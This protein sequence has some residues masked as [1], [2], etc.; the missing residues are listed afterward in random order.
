MECEY[1]PLGTTM[2]DEAKEVFKHIR[3]TW[4]GKIHI[5]FRPP[6]PQNWTLCDFLAKST[7]EIG[8][9][10]YTEHIFHSQ[11]ELFMIN[12]ALAQEIPVLNERTKVVCYENLRSDTSSTMESV[13]NFL[14]NG[15]S[16]VKS[17]SLSFETRKLADYTGSHSDSGDTD[18]YRRLTQIIQQ[19][20]KQYYKGD[21]AW[22]DSKFP[23]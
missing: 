21:I 2:D 15:T 6:V 20:D 18:M 3:K 7:E 23:C 1:N 22:L 14:F 17:S 5:G 19:M 9:R 16:P 13:F 11:Y 12:W 10:A 4:R 8:L